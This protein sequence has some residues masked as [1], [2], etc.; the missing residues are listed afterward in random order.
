MILI[1][2]AT[3]HIGNVLTHKLALR[4]PNE[5]IRIFL[6]P[7]ETLDLFDRLHLELF[8]GDIRKEADV[9][10]AV[11]GA[12]L[13]FHL[14]GLIDTSLKPGKHIFE[15]NVGGTA[16]VVK[17]CEQNL[18][19]QLVY[20]SSVHALPDLPGTE[21]IT[22]I[23]SFPVP[24]LLGGYAKSK[25]QATAIVLAAAARGLD[26]RI[27]FPS[28]VIGPADYKL[29]DMGRLFRY[30]YAIRSLKLVLSFQGAY[31]FVD[32]RDVAEGLIAIAE[33]GCKGEG[34]ILSGD[35]I[36]IQEIIHLERKILGRRAPLILSVP[37]WLVKAGAF[38]IASFAHVFQI[39]AIVTPYSIAVLQ[40]N[41]FISHD[42]AS[43]EL[44]YQ[45]RSIEMSIKDSLVWMQKLG[46]IH[47][48]K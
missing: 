37:V 27:A 22:E 35:R 34:Y 2:G 30:F 38:L 43:R 31:N 36:S 26:A 40:S 33:K 7:R 18:G 45:P 48:A 23:S 8:Y 39:H 5:K 47:P 25:S 29:S 10:A 1:T 21:T 17:A 15:I 19:C 3:G 46:L 32:V 13:V 4:Y 9:A 28:G 14:A 16:N 11:S 24:D 20:V 6:M 41:S 44:G 42:K 12:R